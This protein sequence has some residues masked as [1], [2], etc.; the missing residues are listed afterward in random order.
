MKGTSLTLFLGPQGSFTQQAAKRLM[1]KAHLREAGSI[2]E[3]FELL[4]K[5]KDTYA[6]VP[7]RNSLAGDVSETVALLQRYPMVEIESSH[8]LK[9][10]L[11]LAANAAEP[12]YEIYSKDIAFEQCS[13]FLKVNYPHVKLTKVNSTSEGAKLAT[14]NPHTAAIC[15]ELAANTYGLSVLAKDIQNNQD[16]QTTFILIRST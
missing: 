9:V 14:E 12:V 10:S 2:E 3:I 6:I 13:V 4:D 5:Q 1:P 15:S 11:C 16:N 7:L 8:V